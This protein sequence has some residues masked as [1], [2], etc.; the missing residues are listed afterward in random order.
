MAGVRS[1]RHLRRRCRII[2]RM[3]RLAQG[4][5]TIVFGENTTIG[6][7]AKELALEPV[8]LVL[9]FVYVSGKG[10]YFLGRVLLIMQERHNLIM[11][12]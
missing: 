9:E 11:A 2:V 3:Q 7:C 10:R 6:F 4:K 8:E 1:Y 12:Y 5:L